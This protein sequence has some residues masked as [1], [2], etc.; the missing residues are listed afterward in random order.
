M[1]L[2][3][4]GDRL[5][6]DLAELAGIGVDPAGGLSRTA[7]SAADARAREW[8]AAKCAEA[9]LEVALDGLGNMVAGLPADD[10]VPL[11]TRLTPGGPLMSRPCMSCESAPQR[12]KAVTRR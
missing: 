4:E 10:A 9:G 11:E 5:L 6:R 12:S 8:Y 7:F 3:V 1:T 2:R